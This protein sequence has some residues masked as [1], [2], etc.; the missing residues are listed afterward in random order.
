[1]TN[2]LPFTVSL[3]L[4]SGA[5]TAADFENALAESE[6]ALTWL[7]ESYAAKS[8]E[9]LRVPE[10]RDDIEAARK[11]AEAWRGNTTDVAV[12]GIGGSSLGGQALKELIPFGA[13]QRPRLTFFDNADPFTFAAALKSYDLRS[14]RFI[15][16]SKSGGTAETLSQALAAAGAIDAAGGGKYLA[17]HFI[18][19]TEPKPSALKSFAEGIGCPVLDHPLGVGGRYAVLTMVGILPAILMGLDVNALRAGAGDVVQNMLT[20]KNA[21]DV[22]ALS[23]AALHH[24]FGR[25]L[26]ETVLWSYSDALKTFG[27]WWRQL[28]AESLGKEGQGTTPVAALGPVDQHSQLQLFLD[29]PGGALYTIVTTDTN[30]AG[31]LIPAARADAL[32]LS[33]LSGKHLGDLVA[34]EARATA[35]TLARRG[36]PVRQIHVPKIDARAMGALMMHFMLETIAMGRLMGV[37][38]FDQPAVEEGKVLARQYLSTPP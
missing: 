7:R 33:Y 37:D 23:G 5:V 10:R 14:T 26:R 20:A 16:I 11:T 31:P 15:A 27:P 36:R 22:P 28:W 4:A 9:L 25:G 6:A 30:G 17:Q 24:S 38:P 35:E 32:K 34:A 8:L 21:S 13:E 12:L 1:M 3:A 19:V 2:P 29:G 18:A